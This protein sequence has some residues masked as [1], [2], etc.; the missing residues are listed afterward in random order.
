MIDTEAD[1]LAIC[2]TGWWTK[3]G[4]STDTWAEIL[5]ELDVEP[6]AVELALKRLRK[7]SSDPPDMAALL[8][9]LR[10]S[11]SPT[12]P[13]REYPEAVSLEQ[14]LE[15]LEEMDAGTAATL[16]R[17]RKGGGR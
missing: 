16:A 12:P 3:R 9:E 13:R 5:L 10:S 14:A 8:A 15:S 11:S 4:L 1:R 6:E 2:A 7:R 17:Y